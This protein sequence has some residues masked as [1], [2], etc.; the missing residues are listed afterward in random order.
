MNDLY[1]KV[2]YGLVII[3]IVFSLDY[4]SKQLVLEYIPMYG[5]VDFIPGFLVFTNVL[6]TGIAFSFLES[7]PSLFIIVIGV[8]LLGYLI[9]SFFQRKNLW[10]LSGL[11]MM[12]GGTLGNLFDRFVYG[13]VVD[14]IHFYL[15]GVSMPIFNVADTFIFIGICCWILGEYLKEKNYG[16]KQRRTS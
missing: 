16:K 10:V 8:V 13:G 11:S 14:F 5:Q 15:F 6:N 2:L 3:L 7:F 9:Y 1:K 12:I 4:L